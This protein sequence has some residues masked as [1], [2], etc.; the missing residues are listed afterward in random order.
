MIREDKGVCEV[1]EWFTNLFKSNG[2]VPQPNTVQED[3]VAEYHKIK[4]TEIMKDISVC[5]MQ[6][7]EYKIVNNGIPIISLMPTC[8]PIF[9]SGGYVE[10]KPLKM[11]KSHCCRKCVEYYRRR[12]N[13]LQE[14]TVVSKI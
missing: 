8:I 12:V 5:L 11:T 2:K 13:S 3:W 9:T 1:W 6:N 4:D 10:S 7:G 14:N